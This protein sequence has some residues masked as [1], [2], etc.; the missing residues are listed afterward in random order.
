M[1]RMALY[2]LTSRLAV[3]ARMQTDSQTCTTSNIL[4]LFPLNPAGRP[5][6]AIALGE[7]I[8]DE[9]LSAPPFAAETAG[10][11][12]DALYSSMAPC[13]QDTAPYAPV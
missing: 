8:C 1:S 3:L 12:L 5:L 6:L 2:Y 4:S 13:F 9:C 7:S 10:S 11:D